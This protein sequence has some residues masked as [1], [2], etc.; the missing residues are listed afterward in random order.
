MGISQ[1]A[2]VLAAA[3]ASVGDSVISTWD[4]N[5]HYGFWRPVTAIRLADTD[6]N[7]KTSSAETM[8]PV[9]ARRCRG[10]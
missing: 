9:R 5:F 2:Q 7:S 1:V 4:A 10:S 3:D 6:D 8:H